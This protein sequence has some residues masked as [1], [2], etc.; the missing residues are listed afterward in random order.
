MSY[1]DFDRLDAMDDHA[2]Q[3]QK[4]YPFANPAGLLTDEGYERFE[5]LFTAVG[6]SFRPLSGADRRR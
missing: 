3:T 5:D 1:L 4:P 6:R 2:F